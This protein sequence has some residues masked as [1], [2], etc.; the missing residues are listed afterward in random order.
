MAAADRPGHPLG[1]DDILLRLLGRALRDDP[2][3]ALAEEPPADVVAAAK[4]AWGPGD[5]DW[6]LAALLADTTADPVL[7]GMRGDVA[8]LRSLVFEG[9]GIRIEVE[10]AAADG[11]L[12]GQ[13]EPA[14]AATVELHTAG[15]IEPVQAD[16]LGRFRFALPTGGLRLRVRRADA[17]DLVTP[18]VSR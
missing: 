2:D 12:L 4:A 16:E 8:Q 7:S 18:W 14:A 3:P 9:A 6:E 17:P 11:E 5:L 13:L 10:L 15:G 1:D